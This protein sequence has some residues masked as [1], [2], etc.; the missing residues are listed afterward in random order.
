M[1]P[2][3]LRSIDPSSHPVLL[4]RAQI[5]LIH[6]VV[7]DETGGAHGV[8][9]SH[10]LEALLHLP[11]QKFGG[12]ELYPGLFLKSALYARNIIEGR[13]FIDGNKR[14][15]MAASSIFLE[16]NGYHVIAKDGE[17]E[18]YTLRIARERLRVK[19]I[20]MWFKVR[21]KKEK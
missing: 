13:I 19:D 14:S 8:R 17:I 16:N 12:K 9:D 6:S 21:A 3:S 15:G 2:N 20:A 10:G 4:S 5:L 1:T 7:I 11:T 18:R